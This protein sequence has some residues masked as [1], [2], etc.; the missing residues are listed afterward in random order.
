MSRA[1]VVIVGGGA[2]GC[3]LARELAG[4]DHSVTVIERAEPG[5]EAS[6]AAAGLIAPQ[7]EGLPEGPL[8]EI[9]VA[10]RA[11]YP[12]LAAELLEES[13]IDVGWRRTGIVRCSFSGEEDWGKYLW[14]RARGLAVESI[15]AER[16]AELTEEL[17]AEDIRSALFLPDDGVV[18]PRRLTRALWFAAER[19]GVRF[20][21]GTAA[22]RLN[23]ARGRC[24]GVE[25]D[26]GDFA[27]D[28][29]VDASGAWAAFDPEAPSIGVAPVRGQIVE[30]RPAERS[31]PC[32][33]ESD[34][35]Y[36]LPREDGSLLVG[37]TEERAGFR[38]EVTAAAIARLIAAACRL[39][40]SLAGARFTGAWAGLRPASEDGLPILGASS[41]P[42]LFFGAGHFRNGILL[43]PITAI[44]LA[45]ALE[46]RT[47]EAL[48][49]FSP[50]RF[51][52]RA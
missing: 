51:E 37:S 28:A 20:L 31:I 44:L 32:V 3:A 5:A 9:A 17:V 36:L 13:G 22:R 14:Q 23:I 2:I 42:G 18:D 38:K 33:V 15:G 7:A 19:R 52:S 48:A 26:R 27:G 50:Q 12:S 24:S 10:S 41:L 39:V 21:L 1:S 25:T 6:G 30:L 40:P 16:V 49:A 8:F 34:D 29:V 43:A 47:A 45:D 11:L 4:R 46:G 35:A